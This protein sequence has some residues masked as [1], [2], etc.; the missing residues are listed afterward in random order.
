MIN[1]K[2]TP[3]INLLVK[4][5]IINFVNTQEETLILFFFM[6]K[7]KLMKK[8]LFFKTFNILQVTKN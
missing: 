5:K 7:I 4:K 1:I 8:R 3:N 6:T 2:K